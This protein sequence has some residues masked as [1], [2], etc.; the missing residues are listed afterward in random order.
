MVDNSLSPHGG[1]LV[2]R[3]ADTRD[4]AEMV[5]GLPRLPVREQIARECVNIAYGFFS[6]LEG[7]MGSADVDSV[8]RNMTLAN[9]YIWSIPLLLDVSPQ[10]LAVMGIDTGGSLLLTYQ[11]QPLAVMEVEEV[12]SY[13]KEFMAQQVYA[14]TDVEHPG[15]ARTYSL[16]DRFVAGPITLVNPPVINPPL[17]QVLADTPASFARPSRVWAGTVR[18]PTRAETFPIAA[19]NG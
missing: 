12:F 19:T 2:E 7:F 15:V 9:G 16:E 8:V 4:A 18:W 14:T 3:I 10:T 5:W 6:P 13:D 11:D 17:R 1:F